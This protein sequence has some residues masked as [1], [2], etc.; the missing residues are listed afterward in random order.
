MTL[1]SNT[2]SLAIFKEQVLLQLYVPIN[3]Q[4][5]ETYSFIS[6]HENERNDSCFLAIY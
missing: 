2:S 3:R 1:S 6:S 4:L 5:H